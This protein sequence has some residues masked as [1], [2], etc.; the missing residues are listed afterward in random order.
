MIYSSHR[1]LGWQSQLGVAIVPGLALRAGRASGV[2]ATEIRGARRQIEAA[3]HGGPADPVPAGRL[4]EALIRA[5]AAVD[6]TVPV[7]AL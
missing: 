6:E 3:S 7:P 2:R 5:A 1:M 4:I